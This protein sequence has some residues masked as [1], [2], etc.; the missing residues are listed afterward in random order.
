MRTWIATAALVCASLGAPR[1]LAQ[2]PDE[3]TKSAA[4][5]LAHQGDEAF[6]RSDFAGA[7]DRFER[8]H[9]LIRA[10]TL[11]LRQAHC[12]VALGRLVQA[13]ERYHD[14]LRARIA[15][16]APSAYRSAVET[17]RIEVAHL[18][19]RIPT[20]E[21]AVQGSP[22]ESARLTVDGRVIPQAL[23]NAGFPVDPGA[24]R[25][26]LEDEGHRLLEAVVLAEGES[27]RLALSLQ[28]G[29]TP[30]PPEGQAT[31]LPATSPRTSGRPAGRASDAP[32]SDGSPQRTVGW[33]VLGV[34][35][36]GIALG[37]GTGLWAAG[38]RSDLDSTCA[39]GVCPDS[40]GGDVDSYNTLRRV[41][42][43]SFA[44]GAVAAG[45]GLVLVVTSPQAAG[46]ARAG[47]V[48]LRLGAGTLAV[49]GGF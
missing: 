33:V 37:A 26:E 42:T 7:L 17:A 34:G 45:T 23:W 46:P 41:S 1:A 21:V 24:H 11:L 15:D 4:R 14:V 38:K 39:G 18:R 12:L 22:S 44:L 43:L 36:A 47:H 25:V 28:A 16:D 30:L 32:A 48:S 35:A 6:A 2:E 10:P 29:A 13:S 20:L 31:G 9:V 5:L 3:A 40:V 27:K 49:G 8:A 19:K